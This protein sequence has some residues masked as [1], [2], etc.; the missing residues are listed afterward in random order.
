MCCVNAD[1]ALVI[2]PRPTAQVADQVNRDSCDTCPPGSIKYPFTGDQTESTCK[3]LTVLANANLCR[4][5][6]VGYGGV[7]LT[8]GD[9]AYPGKVSRCD[10]SPSLGF[11]CRFPVAFCVSFPPLPG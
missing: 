6:Q 10:C 7:C 11:R 1:F 9:A 5:N 8:C 4:S 2:A 3:D